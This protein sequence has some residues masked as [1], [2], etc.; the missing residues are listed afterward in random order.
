MDTSKEEVITTVCSCHCGGAACIVK[1]HIKDGVIT[2][3]ETDDGEEPQLRACARGRSY[4]QRVYAPDRLRFPMRRVGARG[5]GK[6]ERITWDEALEQV[7]GELKRI[8]ETY[9]PAAIALAGSAGDL[10][11]LHWCGPIQRLLCMMGG[12]TRYWGLFSNEG[13]NF[14][15]LVRLW[16]PN[17]VLLAWFII[18]LIQAFL[19]EPRL[20]ATSILV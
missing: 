18:D 11:M 8:K 5:E 20:G 12:Y 7:A 2:R 13:G 9:G 17:Q 15:S 4:R 6:F 19:Q 3:L 10:T 14:A 1:A 16:N